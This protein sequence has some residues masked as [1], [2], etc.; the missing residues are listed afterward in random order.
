V[1][2]AETKA[3]YHGHL[4]KNPDGTLRFSLFDFC[5]W[6]ISGIATKDP[7]GGYFLVGTLGP[8]PPALQLPFEDPDRNQLPINPD[9]P[10]TA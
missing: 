4:D 7:D 3:R 8:T 5:D 10:A 6:E 2:E 9:N 1:N